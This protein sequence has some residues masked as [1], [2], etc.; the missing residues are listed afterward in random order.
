MIAIY[1]ISE[2]IFLQH[3]SKHEDWRNIKKYVSGIIGI[4]KKTFDQK[5]IKFKYK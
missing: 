3:F 1:C 5:E 2:N 4:L